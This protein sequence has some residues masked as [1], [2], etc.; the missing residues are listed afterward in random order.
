MIDAALNTL[1]YHTTQNSSF[2]EFSRKVQL[3]TLKEKGQLEVNE[4]FKFLQHFSNPLNFNQVH[5]FRYGSHHGCP[6]HLVII[7]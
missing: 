7:T 4:A 5:P 2:I 6:Q 3:F 1:T